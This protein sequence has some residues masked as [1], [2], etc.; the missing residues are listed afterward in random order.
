MLR[1]S[2]PPP[3]CLLRGGGGHRRWSKGGGRD[4]SGGGSCSGGGSGLRTGKLYYLAG[5][6]SCNVIIG[7][8]VRPIEGWHA[9]L[10]LASARVAAYDPST[11]H[12][13][14]VEVEGV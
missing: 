9:R 13:L 1:Y 4:G 10:S 11:C 3:F 12:S 14:D 6:P 8:E 5:L 2:S 7:A